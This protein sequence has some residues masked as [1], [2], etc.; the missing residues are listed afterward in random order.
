MLTGVHSGFIFKEVIDCDR[1]VKKR[2]RELQQKNT[3]KKGGR[4]FSQ[5]KKKCEIAPCPQPSENDLPTTC[6]LLCMLNH[7]PAPALFFSVFS[8]IS[9]VFSSN[10]VPALHLN[11]S[12][13]ER[14]WLPEELVR[15][16]RIWVK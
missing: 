7:I 8:K 10:H 12:G 1:S 14:I 15:R 16:E 11:D 2:K 6:F 5:Q 4:I 9:L 13:E 3:V